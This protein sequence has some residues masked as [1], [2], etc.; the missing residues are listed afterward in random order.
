MKP[1]AKKQL[2]REIARV[3][4]AAYRR[5]FQQGHEAAASGRHLALELEHW[6]FK[7]P[8]HLSRCPFDGFKSTAEE[9]LRIEHPHM[10]EI[11]ERLCHTE[12]GDCD[13]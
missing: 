4:E 1:S 10:V 13:E 6:R 7:V 2:L 12:G 8:L 3:T 9:R 11:V 5:G